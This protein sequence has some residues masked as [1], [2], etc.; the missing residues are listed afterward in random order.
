MEITKETKRTGRTSTRG[1][2][3]R[4]KALVKYKPDASELKVNSEKDVEGFSG[5]CVWMSQRTELG[6][7]RVRDQGLK[8]LG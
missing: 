6:K 5:V 4:A 1:E 7:N 8:D 2:K 3:I